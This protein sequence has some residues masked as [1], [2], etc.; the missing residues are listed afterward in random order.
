MWNVIG[1]FPSYKLE[2]IEPS[3]FSKVASYKYLYINF[4][5]IRYFTQLS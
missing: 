3:Y 1:R 5:W 4:V 2:E